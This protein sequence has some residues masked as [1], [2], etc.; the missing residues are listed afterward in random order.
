MDLIKDNIN[1]KDTKVLLDKLYNLMFI[2]AKE[3]DLLHFRLYKLEKNYKRALDVLDI[4]KNIPK[5]LK[6]LLKNEIEKE[7][8]EQTVEETKVELL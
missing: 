4:S 2:Q 3:I 5:D 8:K 6:E 1:L 7:I